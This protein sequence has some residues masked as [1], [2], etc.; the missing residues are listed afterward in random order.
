MA[1]NELKTLLQSRPFKPFTV[2]LPNG[3]GFEIPHPEFAWLTPTGRTLIVGKAKEDGVDMLE[4]PLITR[5]QVN[6]APPT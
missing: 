3:A 5:V 6:P 1:P 2:F 4:V